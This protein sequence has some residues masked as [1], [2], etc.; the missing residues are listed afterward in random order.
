[1]EFYLRGRQFRIGTLAQFMVRKKQFV[2]EQKAN[3]PR[4][5]LTEAGAGKEAVPD[6]GIGSIGPADR[7]E[8]TGSVP[9]NE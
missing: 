5:P 9:Y 2:D 3:K 4:L 8:P 7:C 1:M 6:R